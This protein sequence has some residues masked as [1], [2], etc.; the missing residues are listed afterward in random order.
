MIA[1]LEN[2]GPATWGLPPEES[3]SVMDLLRHQ[4]TLYTRLEGFSQKQRML[5]AEEDNKLLLALLADRQKLSLELAKLS[6]RLGP[7]RE[8]WPKYRETMTADERREAAG[9]LDGMRSCLSRVLENDE[10]DARVLRVRKHM[11]RSA[12]AES[13]SRGAAAGAYRAAAASSGRRLDEEQ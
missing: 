3:G 4:A 6:R 2:A 9:L 1:E 5:V 11:V 12:L 10:Q 8:N 13:Q 7:V